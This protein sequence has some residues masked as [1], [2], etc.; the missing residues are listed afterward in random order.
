MKTLL[1]VLALIY[2]SSNGT[3]LFKSAIDPIKDKVKALRDGIEDA[4]TDVTVVRKRMG[5]VQGN[6]WSVGVLVYVILAI[7]PAVFLGLVTLYGAHAALLRIG[8]A[9]VPPPAAAG[10][11]VPPATGGAP[12]HSPFYWTLFLLS[13]LTAWHLLA[14]YRDGW[15]AWI[16][17]WCKKQEP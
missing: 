3:G 5:A 15:A 2:G 1:A 11:P 9:A 16:K 14:D 8:L 17:G 7:I 4:A 6:L 10:A 12:P 13:V